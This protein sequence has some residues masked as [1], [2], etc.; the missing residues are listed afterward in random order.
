MTFQGEEM[1]DRYDIVWDLICDLHGWPHEDEAS[2]H[3]ENLSMEERFL[4]EDAY[5]RDFND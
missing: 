3:Y 1:R 5:Y 4:L 2:V